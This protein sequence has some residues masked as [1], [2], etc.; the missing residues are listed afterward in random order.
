VTYDEM[1]STYEEHAR[2]SA[3]NAHY[4]RPA[5]LA[6]VG[7]LKGR[8]VLDAGCGPGLYSE[9]LVAR[10]AEVVALDASAKMVELAARRLGAKAEVV[11][12]D[13]NEPLPFPAAAFDLVV[14][15]LVIHHVD[16]RDACFREFFRVLK[17]G[18]RAVVST[19]HPTTDWLRKGGSY[20]ET[21]Q[22]EDT[23]HRGETS[24][25]VRFWREPLS[26]LCAS[27]TDAGF[28]IDRLV[29]P[30]PA[31]SM[32]ERSPED[33]EKLHREPGFIVLRVVKPTDA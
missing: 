22:E 17:P 13:L 29:E 30:L 14:S 6:L 32:R 8:R 19:Q 33:W 21:K 10:G 20:F 7:D 26:A 23:W 1:A 24:Y 9:E 16:D 28:L 25:T 12:A 4:D 15:A 27:I 5:V 11:R 2:D 31:P 18:G 3:Y